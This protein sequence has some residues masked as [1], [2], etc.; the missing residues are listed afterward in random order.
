MNASLPIFAVHAHVATRRHVDADAVFDEHFGA[1]VKDRRGCDWVVV[2]QPLQRGLAHILSGGTATML[3]SCIGRHEGV[4]EA[5]RRVRRELVGAGGRERHADAQRVVHVV[6]RDRVEDGAQA[7]EPRGRNVL[8]DLGG[9][10]LGAPP[11]LGAAKRD[12][13]QHLPEQ[14]ERG[15]TLGIGLRRLQKLYE[16]RITDEPSEFRKRLRR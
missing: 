16:V 3:P 9:A 5:L 6:R 15:L 14:H 4:V 12:E 2:G 11:L 7:K 8:G 1:L 13:G 10:L